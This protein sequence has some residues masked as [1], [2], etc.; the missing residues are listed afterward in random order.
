MITYFMIE[1]RKGDWHNLLG[2][3]IVYSTF[4]DI[5]GTFHKP[6]I[7]DTQG[8]PLQVE[9][10]HLCGVY[11]DIDPVRFAERTGTDDKG[12]AR[13][14]QYL[15]TT[16]PLLQTAPSST[17]QPPGQFSKF[18]NT[19][20][21]NELISEAHLLEQ[22]DDLLY[23]G[24]WGNA[25]NWI[26][27]IDSGRDYYFKLL[28]EQHIL[29]AQQFPPPPTSYQ[30]LTSEQ[31]EMYLQ[32]TVTR[33]LKAQRLPIKEQQS[34]FTHLKAAL[35]KSFT[36]ARFTKDSLSLATLLEQ[37]CTHHGLLKAHVRKIAALHGEQYEKAGELVQIIRVL[38]SLRQ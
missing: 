37:G 24:S 33:A 12:K 31:L 18:V 30:S 9:E 21:H 6:N 23:M 35:T 15:Q 7:V 16:T 13:I 8:R 34:Y 14:Q 2:H 10:G 3:A 25:L 4:S 32:D 38:S 5:T 29:R 20:G 11:I 1:L 27:A 22:D 17:Y 26:S 28:E 19:M 36:G